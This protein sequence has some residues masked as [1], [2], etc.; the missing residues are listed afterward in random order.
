MS[1][2]NEDN[3][4]DGES[5]PKKKSADLAAL[6]KQLKAQGDDG[7]ER[8]Q[9]LK[10]TLEEMERQTEPL[11]R[12]QKQMK[13]LQ[14]LSE[15][16][17]LAAKLAED[18]KRYSAIREQME[19]GLEPYR[20]LQ[21][22]MKNLR[23]SAG[24]DSAVGRVAKQ[25]ADQQRALK[26]IRPNIR[27]DIAKPEPPRLSNIE[28]IK[29]PPNPIVE[30]NERLERIEERFEQMQDIATD[31][32][33]IANGLQ[34]AAAEFLQKF[35]EAAK[36]ND[37]TAGRAI[38]IGAVAVIIAIA[39]PAVQI[40]YSEFRRTPDYGPKI[41]SVLEDVQAEAA[42]L[43]DAQAE[44]SAQLG[45]IID[46]SNYE[47]ATILREIRDLLSKRLVSIESVYEEVPQ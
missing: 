30:T 11:R 15:D 5:S 33:Q 25:I 22:R 13:N 9:A 3:Q 40:G 23:L 12:V 20:G 29:V 18:A 4:G 10:K 2:D 1:N 34:G 8:G 35:E 42:G 19:K 37:R 46:S 17:S 21:D 36:E 24:K 32:A 41:Q 27:D 44:A 47:T 14:G 43:R 26:A 6:C 38:L 16:K 7:G 45:E 31:A 39:M 28:Q